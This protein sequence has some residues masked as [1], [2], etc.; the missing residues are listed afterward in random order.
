MKDRIELNNDISICL[1]DFSVNVQ[2]VTLSCCTFQSFIVC[3]IFRTT[4]WNLFKFY[5]LD[6]YINNCWLDF[7]VNR[8]GDGTTLL[9]FLRLP[10]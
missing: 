5:K 3:F 9:Y 8:E 10:Q 4:A 6:L 7:R 1:V 2:E